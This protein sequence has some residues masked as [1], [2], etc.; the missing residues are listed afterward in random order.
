MDCSPVTLSPDAF[1]EAC[2]TGKRG[3]KQSVTYDRKIPKKAIHLIRNPLDNL[4]GRM[5]LFNKHH[6]DRVPFETSRGGLAAW[7]KYL[8]DKYPVDDAFRS[9]PCQ[10]EWFRYVQ[11]HNLAWETTRT[12]LQIPV[13]YLYYDQ[14][15]SRYNETLRGVLDFLQLSAVSDPLPFHAGKTY[16]SLFGI[17]H[18]QAA[19]RAVKESALPEVWKLLEPY[20]AELNVVED[21]DDYQSSIQEKKSHVEADL[22]GKKPPQVAWLLS[23]PNSVCYIMLCYVML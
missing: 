12:R 23:Y 4:V 21:A 14:Y 6:R 19:A 1:E 7:C 10:A 11:W 2:L 16:Q 8:D 15:A 18:M 13:H 17:S 20:F 9:V 3:D 5:H 22:A